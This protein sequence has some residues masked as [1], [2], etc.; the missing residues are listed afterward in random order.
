MRSEGVGGRV[1]ECEREV[2]YG[3]EKKK[4]QMSGWPRDKVVVE[5]CGG[6]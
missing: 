6:N 4:E 2:L 1:K 3:E 5:M